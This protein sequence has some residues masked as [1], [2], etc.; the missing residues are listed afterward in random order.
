MDQVIFF[1]QYNTDTFGSL[2]LTTKTLDIN[3]TFNDVIKFALDIQA[4]LI[5]KPSRGNFWYIK[6]LNEPIQVNN[7]EEHINTNQINNFKPKT[8]LWLIKYK[9]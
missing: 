1:K 7:L 4:N 6:K 9:N 2:N 5:V 3:T 8:T